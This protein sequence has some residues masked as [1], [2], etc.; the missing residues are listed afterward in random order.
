VAGAARTAEELGRAFPGA[1]VVSSAGDHVKDTVGAEPAL[2]V[3]T[4][5]AEPVAA[6]GYAA[7]LLLDGNSMLSRESL[8]ASEQTLRRWFN[9]AS[10]VRPA[11]EGGIVVVTADSDVV[12][13]QLV[14]WDPAG[15]ASRELGLRRELQLPP[16]VRIAALTGSAAGIE[17]FLQDLPLP[18][19]RLVGPVQL[20]AAAGTD[21]PAHRLLIF[22]GYREAAEVAAALRTRKAAL[23]ARRTPDPVQVRLDGLDLV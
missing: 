16:A 18:Q 8:R 12:V 23:S 2:V 4:P 11:A 9:A 14:R 10:L 5:G 6:A 20:P 21:E 1:A 19:A 3:A 15:A 22:F 17:L 13:G 7:A